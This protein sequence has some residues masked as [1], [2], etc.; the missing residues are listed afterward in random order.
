MSTLTN[1]TAVTLPDSL[2]WSDEFD[3]TAVAQRVGRGVTGALFV[4]EM[5]LSSGRTITLQGADDRGWLPRAALETL[6]GWAQTPNLPMTLNLRGTN[7][8]VIFDRQQGKPIEA[9]PVQIYEDVAAGDHYVVTL[10][11]IVVA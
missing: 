8:S 7:Y 6:Y 4:D 9:R 3:F 2:L 5:A 11:F 10:H 1:G